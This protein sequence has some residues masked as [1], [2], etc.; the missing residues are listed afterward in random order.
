V[1]ILAVSVVVSLLRPKKTLSEMHAEMEERD[2]A[3]P[4]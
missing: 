2:R 3:L 4:V 1:L